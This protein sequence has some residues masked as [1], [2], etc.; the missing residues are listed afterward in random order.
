MMARLDRPRPFASR[1]WA[2][3]DTI[4]STEA[5]HQA[6][7]RN[8]LG[9]LDAVARMKPRLSELIQAASDITCDGFTHAVLLGMGGSS[10]APEVLRLTFGART[11][12]LDLSV[13]DNTSPAAVQHV[14]DTH[15][16]E[17]TFFLVSS[18]SG[19]GTIEVASFEKAF[20]AWVSAARG[21]DAGR[22]FAAITDPG[23]VLETLAK[24]RGYRKIF[25]APP[26]VGGR[27]SALTEFGLVPAALMGVDVGAMLAAAEAESVASGANVAGLAN[28]GVGL[29]AWL[30][31]L[32]VDGR[33]KMTL[34]LGD[35]IAA[36]GSWVE[37]LVA[38]ST[39]KEGKGI[40]P[41][42]GE[43][44][45]PPDVYRGDRLFVAASSRPLSRDVE[46]KLEALAAAGHPVIRWT[47][48][49][50][51]AVG[52][53][54]LRWEIATATAGA[55]LG[56][57]PF[58]EPNVTEAKQ[59]TQAVLARYLETGSFAPRKPVASGGG[60]DVECPPAI[61]NSLRDAT[62]GR[63]DASSW[64][65]ALLGMAGSGDY[66]AL[67]GYL[68]ATPARMERLEALR[69]ACRAATRCATTL[70]VGPRF[71][72]STGQLHKGGANNGV[73]IQLLADEGDAAQI[74]GEKYGFGALRFAQAA[75]DYEVLAK[76]DR[77]VIRLH[78]G[79]DVERALD[80]LIAG[81]SAAKV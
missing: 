29:G 5:V 72:H 58:D 79:A 34:V 42:A 35:E 64:L 46:A 68:H 63:G 81:V 32:A 62:N 37:Q 14:M 69:L 30:G 22:S 66:V 43:A 77:R 10:L 1:L 70:G 38:E 48:P 40:V 52:G 50:L 12:Y 25:H 21:K 67:L 19:G 78:L 74:P 75:G 28:P 51:A 16:P 36:L 8:R 23:T 47:L 73:F 65:A 17:R 31:A 4:W 41:I 76:R 45:G 56:V 6:V 24:D 9:W 18:K 15:H 13:L 27:Y 3:D 55:A 80:A 20:F 44:L 60:I 2:K 11:G 61:E 33:D 59:A 71:L 57:D 7:A 49:T 53:D 39:G 54:F 26:D